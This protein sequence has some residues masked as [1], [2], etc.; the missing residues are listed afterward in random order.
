MNVDVRIAYFT[1]KVAEL[2]RYRPHHDDLPA[3]YG[4]RHKRL[5]AYKKAMHKR[6]CTRR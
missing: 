2:G 5:M 1:R 6:I 4:S 3:W